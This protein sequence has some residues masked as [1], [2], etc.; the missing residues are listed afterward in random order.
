[1]P[2][3]ARRG[4]RGSLTSA[5]RG[6]ETPVSH[7]PTLPT[8]TAEDQGWIRLVGDALRGLDPERLRA[9]IRALRRL[10]NQVESELIS[11][12]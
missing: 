5:A 3:R 7:L 2:K 8:L 1:M 9:Y 6:E 10:L 12:Q 11:D 4:I